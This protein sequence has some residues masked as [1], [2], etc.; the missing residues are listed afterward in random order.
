MSNS[1]TE[2][3]PRRTYNAAAVAYDNTSVEF[4]RYAADETVRRLALQPG[5][6]VLDVACGP[7]P[8]AL[9]AARE[10][11]SSGVV[12]GI[13]I[14][15]EMIALAQKH[16][17]E[18]G[19]SNTTFE[20]RNMDAL[21]FPASS[22]DAATCVFGLFFAE[23]IVATI[24]AMKESLILDGR[25][26]I[27]T[28]GPKFFSPM[29]DVF[30]DA[31][32]VEN[33]EIDKNVPWRRTQDTNVMRGYLCSAGVVAVSVSHEVS[34]LRLRSPEDWWRIVMGTGIRRLV[35]DLEVDA[36]ERVRRHNLS[37]IRDRELDTLEL[38]V[39][40]CRGCNPGR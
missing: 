32:T 37:W 3:D 29:F 22:F 34:G 24:R 4:W 16:A 9:A 12:V 36:V 15:E 6:R 26:A 17:V 7:G 27:T 31:A 35:M 33:P 2:F 11:G 23:D 40:Y 20:I 10:V 39:V 38:G 13:D 25:I 5:E 14:A 18:Q 21:D 30:L 19:A 1:L 28:L 8:A